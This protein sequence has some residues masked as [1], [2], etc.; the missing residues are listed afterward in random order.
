MQ[1]NLEGVVVQRKGFGHT[2]HPSA[3]ISWLVSWRP[4][5]TFVG[6][7]V[8]ASALTGDAADDRVYIGGPFQNCLL[9]P[10]WVINRQLLRILTCCK[11]IAP[12]WPKPK[13]MH[14]LIQINEV[15]SRR[16]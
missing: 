4:K 3:W 5:W 9:V 6:Q 1:L 2:C 14:G 12:R 10:G 8:P 7:C 16:H 13:D 11:Q 15:V